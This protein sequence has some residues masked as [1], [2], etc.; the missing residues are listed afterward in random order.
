M[1]LQD[2]VALV[3]G[4]GGGIGAAIARAFAENGARVVVAD[5]EKDWAKRTLQ[6][7]PD[8]D[9][10]LA[11]ACDVA[12]SASVA[13]MFQQARERFERIDVLVNN[14][15]IG[16]AG[17][18]GQDEYMA[19]LAEQA[20]GKQVFADRTIHTTDAGWQDVVNVNLNGAFFCSREAV[21]VMSEL[22]IKG[23][24]VNISST[25]A[26]NGEGGAHYCAS[27]A[28]IIGLTRALAREL[29]ARGIRVNAICPGPTD[30]RLM[31]GISEEWAA[32]IIGAVPLGRLAQPE[33]IAR[34]AL[35]LASAEDSA[36]FS[37]Q[38]LACNGG[39][40]ML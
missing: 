27:K 17:G 23:A 8:A 38:T 15:G 25:S 13:A 21:R 35:F 3:T 9:E 10:A 31:E 20:Q 19:A 30:T 34:T 24:I 28:A 32:A 4:A 18:D 16:T 26:L 37:G 7:L 39:M 1:K 6:T 36:M 29:A 33:E 11:V 12:D 2:K 40:H 22:D 14:A 5:I